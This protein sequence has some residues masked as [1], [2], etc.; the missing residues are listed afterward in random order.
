MKSII[1]LLA[2]V[3]LTGFGCSVAP[4]GTT[5]TPQQSVFEAKA[6]YEVALTAAVAYKKLPACTAS[7]PPCSTASVV[8]QLQ[9]AQPVARLALD[10]A[11]DAV[12]TPGFGTDIVAS[13]VGAGQAALK[14]FVA[15]TS[16]LPAK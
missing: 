2:F 14:A 4:T 9:K 12:T 8:A 16:T 15:I 1:A 10:A 3:T 13:A 11:Q 6:A 7:Q 5:L